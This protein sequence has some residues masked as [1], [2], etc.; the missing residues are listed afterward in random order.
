MCADVWRCVPNVLKYIDIFDEQ[1]PSTYTASTEHDAG[2][3]RFSCKIRENVQNCTAPQYS[4]CRKNPQSH[5][6]EGFIYR[7]CLEAILVLYS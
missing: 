5:S 2:G 4:D 6:D 7:N 1:T 3:T